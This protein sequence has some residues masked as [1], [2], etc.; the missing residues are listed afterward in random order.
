MI[1]KQEVER[2]KIHGGKGI[3]PWK[4]FL[5]RGDVDAVTEDA[6]WLKERGAL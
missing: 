3:Q 1:Q 5:E 6:E 4:S 2:M